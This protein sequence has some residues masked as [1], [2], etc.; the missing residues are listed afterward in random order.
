M[1]KLNTDAN[2]TEWETPGVIRTRDRCEQEQKQEGD[3]KTQDRPNRLIL[4][5]N[6]SDI[7]CSLH[8]NNFITLII[9]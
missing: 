8:L 3:T 4:Y 7:N 1:Y 2:E 6:I 5:I 9:P